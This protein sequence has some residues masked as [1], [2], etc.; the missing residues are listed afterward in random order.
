M[1]EVWR[2]EHWRLPA[3]ARCPRF[4]EL[5]STESSFR[6]SL[7][8]RSDKVGCD[9]FGEGEGAVLSGQMEG[10]RPTEWPDGGGVWTAGNKPVSLP[11][12]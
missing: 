7:S 2:T 4:T 3:G 9:M 11:K 8:W 12:T 1:E 10:T 6:T 5:G